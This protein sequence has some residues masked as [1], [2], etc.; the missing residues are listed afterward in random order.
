MRVRPIKTTITTLTMAPSLD[1]YGAAEQ[2]SENA[3]TRCQE[4]A[5]EP[6]GGGINVARNLHSLGERVMA[7]F[8]GDSGNG[9]LIEKLL[10]AESVPCR[11]IPAQTVTR[12]NLALTETSSGR[13]FHLVFPGSELSEGEWRD[14]QAAIHSVSDST[15]FLV[16]SGSLPPGVP[17]DF[18]GQIAREAK[19]RAIPVVLDTSG[20]AL[21]AALNSGIYLAKLNPKELAQLG[22][23][24]DWETKSQLQFMAELVRGGLAQL[25]VVTQ[26]EKG[27]LMAT[28][29]GE[30]VQATPPGVDVVSHIGAGDSFV[31]MMVHRLVQGSSD[32]EALAYGVAAA[33]AAI[34]TPGNQVPDPAR[35][36]LLLP[37]I[38]HWD[39]AATLP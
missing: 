3:K 33:A 9:A 23:R 35:V 25:L 11:R 1:L 19:N 6:G 34:S 32:A 12:Q 38:R 30:Y 13:M 21:N 29:S 26:G 24:G 17:D 20:M 22:Y 14:C 16:L 31:S 15:G 18:Y 4:S 10:Q 36:E 28:A 2:L 5:R 37:Q 8:P 27:A 7:I 39:L